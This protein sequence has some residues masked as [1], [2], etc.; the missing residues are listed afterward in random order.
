MGKKN[1]SQ[2]V[3]SK[4]ACAQ[5]MSSRCAMKDEITWLISPSL[6]W[7]QDPTKPGNMYKET[8]LRQTMV[9]E[10]PSTC[11]QDGHLT[12]VKWSGGL[13]SE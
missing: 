7:R 6:G 9:L 10:E 3:N 13:C 12:Q 5:I 11:R 8:N 4:L 1:V 2:A